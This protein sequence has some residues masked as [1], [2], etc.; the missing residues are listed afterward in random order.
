MKTKR[1]EERKEGNELYHLNKK[2][3]GHVKNNTRV[4]VFSKTKN[5][6]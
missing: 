2:N 6:P 4:K 3:A 1:I 5:S